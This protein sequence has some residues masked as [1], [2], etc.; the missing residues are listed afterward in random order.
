[1]SSALYALGLWAVRRR[2]LVV[3]IWL[4]LLV[5]LG[6]AAKVMNRGFVDVFTI[7]GTQSQQAADSLSSRFPQFAGANGQVVV[8]V[9]PGTTVSDTTVKAKIEALTSRYAALPHVRAVASPFNEYVK[10]GISADGSAAIITVQMDVDSANVTPEMRAPLIAEAER[11]TAHGLTAY[12]GGSVFMPSPPEVSITE[13]L[14][15]VV[16]LLV[17]FLTFGSALAAGIPLL[18]SLIGVAASI[19]LIAAATRFT[20]VTSTAPFLGLMIGLAVGIDYALFV[21]SRHRD[22]IA[23]GRSPDQAAAEATGTAGSAV[24]FAGATVGIALVALGVAKIPFLSVMGIAG[25][26]G[27]VGAVIVSLTLL[28]AILG[29]AGARLAPKAVADAHH[30][31]RHTGRSATWV[32]WVTRIPVLTV[33]LVLAALG[34]MAVPAK[35]LRLALPDNGTSAPTST[36]RLAFDAI[37]R[38]FGPGANGPLVITLDI[39]ATTD[40]LG[41]VADVKQLVEKTPGIASVTVATPNPG[42]DTGV[43]VAIPT[44]GSEDAETR[45]TLARV[46]D[47]APD[48]E[49]RHGVSLAVTGHTAAQVDISERLGNALLPFGIL[50][51]GLSLVLLTLVFRSILV[52]V[53]AALGYLLSLGAAF[54]A[55][56]AVF[57]WGWF[58]GPLG[59]HDTGPVIAFM[60]ILLMGVLFGLAMDYQVFLVSTMRSRFVHES[61]ARRSVARGFVDSARVVTAA[62]VIMVAVFAA[63]VPQGAGTIKP[64]ALGLAVGVFVDAFIVRMTLIPA[65]MHLMGDAAWWL[66][67]WLDRRLPVLDVEGE[68]LHRRLE[69]RLDESPLAISAARVGLS[70]NAGAIFADVSIS[71][72]PGAVVLVYGAPGAGKTS[73]LLA[74]A[75][76]MATTEGTLGVAGRILPDQVA[77]VRRVASLA[78]ITGVN[79]LDP[80]L[81]VGDHIGERLAATSWHPWVSGSAR[82]RATARLTNLL[83]YAVSA[84][85]AAH[86]SA[87]IGAQTKVGVLHPL[88]RW[89]VGVAL[90]LIGDP[91][92]LV[93][94][95]VDVLRGD[96]DRRAAWAVLGHLAGLAVRGQ[97]RFGAVAGQERPL[98]IVAS[99]RDSDLARTVLS[100]IP[101]IPVVEVALVRSH[102]ADDDAGAAGAVGTVGT[103]GTVGA[104]D[105]AGVIRSPGRDPDP[106]S[107][108]LD[109][110]FQTEVH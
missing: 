65:L 45:D 22:L 11:S 105:L 106:L 15:V 90:A 17:L 23:E 72:D 68:S 14:G 86:C 28:P 31:R 33:V 67:R 78:E 53:T 44:T 25:A 85:P 83:S 71:A 61:D 30:T 8:A 51:V 59:V 57:Q 79:D 100:G 69:A 110:L 9:P 64:I 101:G 54:G 47:L 52:P 82:D 80:L 39:V 58:G 10:G 20:E 98:T 5:V 43:I 74:L 108:S 109:D 107:N 104:V 89:I 92:I 34:A 46:R 102:S 91:E 97:R 60:P 95:D 13:G 37:A 18:T 19:T 24:V 49:R 87:A 103:V 26:V 70:D 55:V 38:S 2:R 75:G 7:P 48:I 3:I 21:L 99:C 40:P 84:E 1:M 94:D 56:A 81:T 66:P 6:G 16:A 27:V 62:A 29:Y 35:D 42:A 50:V 73:L 88:E 41:V 63:F 77:E 76:R 32:R 93:V 12:I 96:V 4:A 36:Q